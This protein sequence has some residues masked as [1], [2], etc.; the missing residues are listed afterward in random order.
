LQNSY[1]LLKSN[2]L[3]PGNSNQRKYQ[4]WICL[5]IQQKNLG[6]WE[7]I[8]SGVLISNTMSEYST[9]T[10]DKQRVRQNT[11]KLMVPDFNKE[12]VMPQPSPET[13]VRFPFIAYHKLVRLLY[14]CISFLLYVWMRQ[15]WN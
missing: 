6:G 2:W 11:G 10:I 3:F 7:L 13:K 15:A 4:I 1:R 12:A 5:A 14:G 9:L 8:V